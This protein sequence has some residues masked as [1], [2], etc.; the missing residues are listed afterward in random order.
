MY[1]SHFVQNGDV[2]TA[3]YD[4]GTGTPLLFVHGF[5]GSKLDFLNQLAWFS[6]SHRVIAFDHRGHGESS[7]IDP[8]SLDVLAKDLLQFLDALEISTCHV[9]GHSMGGMVV[10][11]AILAAPECFRSLILM[12]TAPHAIDLFSQEIRERLVD[13]VR[14]EGCATLVSGMQGQPQPAS[15]KRGIDFLGEHEHWRRIRVKLEQMDPE[16]FAELGAE[17]A[18]QEDLSSQLDQ[19]TVPT[20]VIVGEDDQPF[21]APSRAMASAIADARLDVIDK[22]AHSP[23]YENPEAWRGAVDAHLMRAG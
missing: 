21:I 23:Q 17:L 9:L 13:M 8:Y 22:A 12:D 5:T 7:N 11:R 15:I 3:Y 19:I 2:Q 18:A 4:V 6:E 14:A 16:A 10:L 1:T 20:S